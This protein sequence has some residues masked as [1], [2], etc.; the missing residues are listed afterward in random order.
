M[1]RISRRAAL[2]KPWRKREK[3]MH[4]GSGLGRNTPSL[5]NC[6]MF[7]GAVAWQVLHFIGSL[8]VVVDDTAIAGN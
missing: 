4:D 3:W 2:H 8:P 6:Q 1:S 7:H 5:V